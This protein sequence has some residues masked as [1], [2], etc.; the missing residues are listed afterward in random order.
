M[1]NDQAFFAEGFRREPR[2]VVEAVIFLKTRYQ[3]QCLKYP[4]MS[5]DIPEAMYVARNLRE[6]CLGR[7]VEIVS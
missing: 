1:T 6:A 5:K 2:T 3:E 7:W 4:T